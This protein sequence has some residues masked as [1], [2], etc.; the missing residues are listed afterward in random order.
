[1][2]APVLESFSKEKNTAYTKLTLLD[3]VE[4]GSFTESKAPVFSVFLAWGFLDA[5]TAAPES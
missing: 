3:S 2:K 1:M 4:T 5:G